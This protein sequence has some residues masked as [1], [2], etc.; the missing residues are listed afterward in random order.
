MADVIKLSQPRPG[1][2][3]F[4][5]CPCQG[6]DGSGTMAVVVMHDAQGAFICAL[7]CPDCEREVPVSF[8]RPSI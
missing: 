6:H 3:S 2:Q 8:G 5:L 4:M 7:V 1:A